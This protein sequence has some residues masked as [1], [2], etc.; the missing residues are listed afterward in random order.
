MSDDIGNISRRKVLKTTAAGGAALTGAS[1]V[2]SASSDLELDV[3]V[4]FSDAAVEDA[5]PVFSPG[6]WG[7]IQ[8][9]ADEIEEQTDITVNLK[10]YEL[11]S[12]TYPH[13]DAGEILEQFREN[14]YIHYGT[15]NLLVISH[16]PQPDVV[17]CNHTGELKE[18][19]KPRAVLN[20]YFNKT[21]TRTWRN[22]IHTAILRPVLQG[23]KSDSAP[24]SNDINSFGTIHTD[25]GWTNEAS[26][27][28][29]WHEPRRAYCP[30]PADLDDL[31]GGDD[32]L[33]SMCGSD[34]VPQA[35]DHTK[36]LSDCTIDAIETQIDEETW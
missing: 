17:G 5:D 21:P 34:D 35:C 14:E 4:W 2:S 28:A 32:H 9:V 19:T 20:D 12:E 1:G 31:I 15:V 33:N 24:D 22:L 16:F 10:D 8:N 23:Q 6:T 25:M 26:P 30:S 29:S 13:G 11:T 36:R 7:Q 3:K 27:L 18:Y